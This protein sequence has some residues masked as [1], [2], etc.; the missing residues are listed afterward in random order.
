MQE[1]KMTLVIP[2]ADAR[3]YN[4]INAI[5]A[6]SAKPYT[7]LKQKDSY[8]QSLLESIAEGEAEFQSQKEAG[9]LTLYESAE[10]AFA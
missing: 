1:A 10:E 7:I 3:L 8:P 9:T 2:N 6:F 5:N 4:L